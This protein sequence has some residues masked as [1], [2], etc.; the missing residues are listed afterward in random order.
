MKNKNIF[1]DL[2][3]VYWYFFLMVFCIIGWILAELQYLELAI[4][5]TIGALICLG[6]ELKAGI[7][8]K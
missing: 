6:L 2:E 3:W 7:F 1:Y 5:F 8:N 4:A